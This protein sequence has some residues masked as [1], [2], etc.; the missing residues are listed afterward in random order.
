MQVKQA[1]HVEM[2]YLS[3]SQHY[4]DFCLTLPEFIQIRI[5]VPQTPTLLQFILAKELRFSRSSFFRAH[6]KT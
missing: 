2:E 3:P 1:R 5:N 6:G 4:E